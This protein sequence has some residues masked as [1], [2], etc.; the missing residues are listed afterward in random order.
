MSPSAEAAVRLSIPMPTSHDVV[1]TLLRPLF[2]LPAL[3]LLA[4]LS[5]SAS[6]SAEHQSWMANG[7][8]LVV[9]TILMLV[10]RQKY[11]RWWFDF[12]V[13]LT[14][15]GLR[16][17]SYLLLLMDSYPSTDERQVV[18][19]EVDY[20]DVQ[21]DLNR[22]MPL[23][24]WLLAI[25]HYL[26]LALL[27]IAA[28]FVTVYAWLTILTSG[29]YPPGAYEFILGL[30]RWTVRVHAYAFLLVTDRYPPF[31]LASSEHL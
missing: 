15:F 11:P 26:V 24:K 3:F 23:F 29:R 9:P 20:P 18:T 6:G 13:E 19:F 25:P 27:W 4:L 31:S 12:N 7:G 17:A 21:R 8:V 10:V 5:G 2:A 16:V 28:V 14:R 1:S 22:W 30:L